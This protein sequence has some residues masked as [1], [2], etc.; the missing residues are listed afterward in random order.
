MDLFN[1]DEATNYFRRISD[2][3]AREIEAFSDEKIQTTNLD[4]WLEYYYAKYAVTLLVLF[5]DNTTQDAVESTTKTS[6]PLYNRVPGD[7]QYWDVPSYTV[8][9]D[10]PFDGSP[11]LL[12]LRP[13]TRIL[14]PF[15]AE[16]RKPSGDSCGSITISLTFTKN[17]LKDK[18][19]VQAF[20]KSRFNNEMTSY[21]K[22]IQY[23]NSDASTFNSQLRKHI[24]NCLKKRKDKASDFQAFREKMNIPLVK[25]GNAP[26][27]VPVPL[28]RIVR[29]PPV[30]PSAQKLE[31]EYRISDEDYKNINN[32]IDMFCLTCEKTAATYA[33]LSEEEIRDTLLSVLNTHYENATGETF[34]K[35]G[36]T[37]ILIE[38]G[39]KAG[40]VAE[41]KVWHGTEGFAKAIDQLFGYITWRDCKAA[42]I[43]F[44]KQ[45]KNF[46]AVRQSIGEWTKTNSIRSSQI[47]AN[48]WECTLQKGDSDEYIE[49]TISVYDLYIG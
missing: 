45:N 7:K 47:K 36:K 5:E 14:V 31:T 26:N 39:N 30:A 25:S 42:L 41:C 27:T 49:L 12:E 20:I 34:R 44:N 18:P 3:V 46:T 17:E 22:M 2:L 9:F 10:I 13:S 1:K 38:F 4:E 16:V 15:S 40:F 43:I 8:T 29:T 24:D 21:R 35:R 37:D 23:V 33:K 19:D 28:K 48:M 32:I 11:E 6:N